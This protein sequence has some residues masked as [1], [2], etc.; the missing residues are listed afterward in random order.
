MYSENLNLL[1]T[2]HFL[3]MNQSCYINCCSGVSSTHVSYAGGNVF[4]SQPHYAVLNEVFH[5][6]SWYFQLIARM[7]HL[8][9][10]EVRPSTSF[11]VLQCYTV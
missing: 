7:E 2:Q 1:V 6:F 11:T 5:G 3:H 9:K 4:T 10:S 8:I